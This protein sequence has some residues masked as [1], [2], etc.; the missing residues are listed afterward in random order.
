MR[1]PSLIAA[2]AAA[3]V[4][5]AAFAGFTAA[6][7]NSPK[8]T[9]KFECS[10]DL[11]VGAQL[12]CTITDV[13]LTPAPVTTVPP[14]PTTTPPTTQPPTTTAPTTSTT[15]P[16]NTLVLFSETFTGDTMKDFTS[17]FDWSVVDL[18]RGTA[19]WQGHHNEACEA[20]TTERVLRHA[21]LSN[22]DPGVE[23]W[24]CGPNGPTSDHLMT[25]NGNNH[26]FGITAFSPKQSFSGNRVCW[27]VNLTESRGRR[28]WW[29]VQL[30]P[31]AAVANE[32]SLASQGKM[33]GGVDFERGT[34]LLAWGQGMDGTFMKRPWPSSSVVFDFTEEM[35][36]IW[37]GQTLAFW[38]G[39]GWETGVRFVTQDRAT[40]ARHCMIDNGNGSMTFTQQRGSQIYTRTVRGASFPK[41]YR[42]IFS[43][44]NYNAGKDGTQSDQTWHWDNILVTS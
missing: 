30:I 9:V 42:V 3:L 26:T 32:T 35:V 14:K 43:A 34:A 20:P 17:V 16:P 6:Q 11:V 37:K 28:L 38:P 40:R 44:H 19:S 22:T 31:A 10:G 21:P 36:R 27:D 39:N 13:R 15:L 5:A 41:P 18:N 23:F 7:D 25:S 29:E 24:L 4:T 8:A 2:P 1:I 12:T 33:V